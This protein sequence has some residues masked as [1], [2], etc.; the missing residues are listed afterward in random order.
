MTQPLALV[1]YE[2]LLPGSQLVNRLRDLGYRVQAIT[3]PNQLAVTAESAKAII[4]VVD[5][6]AKT[7]DVCAQIAA[8]RQ[9]AATSHLPV[10]AYADARDKKLPVAARTAGATIVASAAAVLTQLPQLL[11]Q[12]LEVE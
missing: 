1:V 5:L 8:L 10:L 4:A 11:E 2:N 12:A 9:N 3:D 6:A 7:A